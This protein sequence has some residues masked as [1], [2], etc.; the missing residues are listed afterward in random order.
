MHGNALCYTA[1][2]YNNF[3]RLSVVAVHYAKLFF[4]IASMTPTFT[5][6]HARR[7]KELEARAKAAGSNITQV[8]K[9]TGI[10]RAT[11]ERWVQRAPQ[12]ITKLDELEAEVARLEEEAKKPVTEQA[13]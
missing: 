7:L 12:S 4:W 9:N 3:E 11:Y 6:D 10:A 1:L 8:C 5:Q 13:G 2:L